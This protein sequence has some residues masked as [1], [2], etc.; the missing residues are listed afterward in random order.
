MTLFK[1]YKF[2]GSSVS[3]KETLK[4]VIDILKKD[5]RKKAVVVSAVGSAYKGDEKVTDML[6]KLYRGKNGSFENIEKKFSGLDESKYAERLLKRVERDITE[7]FY[8]D[9]FVASGEYVT[10]KIVA[11]AL[12]YLFVDA[13][14]LFLFD[15]FGKL[16]EKETFDRIKKLNDVKRSVVIPGFYGTDAQG[17]IRLFPRGG[18]DVTGAVLSGALGAK[19]YLNYTDV[20]GILSA[21]PRIVK[22]PRCVKEISY[23]ALKELS[24]YGVKAIHTDVFGYLENAVLK[25]KNTFDENGTYTKAVGKTKKKAFVVTG[26]E[27]AEIVTVYGETDV[28][29]RASD[30]LCLN[31]V[32]VYN[33]SDTPFGAELVVAKTNERVI[34]ELKET[35]LFSKIRVKRKLK[36]LRVAL[37][38]FKDGRAKIYKRLE[39]K[40]IKTYGDFSVGDVFTFVVKSEKYEESVK[41]IYD[42]FTG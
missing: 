41:E 36:L 5:K 31:G 17:R 10:A 37:I 38:N 42:V 3:T 35:P 29:K 19:E 8:Y 21:D 4:K 9:K 28:L 1:V 32:K 11:K 22:N 20:S 15:V 13:K 40:K 16:K 14:D 23:D 25:I 7:D 27:N 12:N 6:I 24:A 26:G 33:V 2:G 30:V 18:G 34:K 39:K